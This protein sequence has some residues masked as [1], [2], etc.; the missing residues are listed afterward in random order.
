MSEHNKKL[1][2]FVK[3]LLIVVSV[4]IVGLILIFVYSLSPGMEST[5]SG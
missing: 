2:R 1:R 3:A 5:L 4:I